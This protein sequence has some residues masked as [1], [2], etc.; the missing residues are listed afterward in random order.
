MAGTIEVLSRVSAAPRSPDGRPTALGKNQVAALLTLLAINYPHPV[1]IAAISEALGWANGTNVH[2]NVSRLRKALKESL[3]VE[4]DLVSRTGAGYSLRLGENITLD[5]YDVM[6][7]IRRTQEE[8]VYARTTQD[9]E[10]AWFS[11]NKALNSL[12]NDILA[13][14]VTSK[15][16]CA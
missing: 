6:A 13:T 11:Y 2:V 3:A 10:R 16:R 15:L 12:P 5:Y 14:A 8:A 1:P 9:F 7:S 4:H